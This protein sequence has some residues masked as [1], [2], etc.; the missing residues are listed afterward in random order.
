MKKI[1]LYLIFL[2]LS[3]PLFSQ[4]G[5]ERKKYIE[6]NERASFMEVNQKYELLGNIA[7][8]TNTGFLIYPDY[9]IIE[10]NNEEYVVF[11]YP[12]FKNGT[13][14]STAT[15][16]RVTLAVGQ[17][18]LHI[19]I[20]GK[21]SAGNT[22]YINGKKLAIQKAKF[23]QLSKTDHYNISWK[24]P[25]NYSLSF[26]VLTVPFKLR[27]KIDSTNFKM[28]TDVTLGPYVGLTKRISS[29]RRYYLTIP[30]TLGLS[31]INIDN[32]NT[33]NVSFDS[34]IGVVPGFTWSTGLIFQLEDFNI[35][36]VLGQDFASGVGDKWRYN[37]EIW[38]SFAIGYNFLNQK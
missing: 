1:Y 32:D 3:S 27:P 30:A 35:G 33:S 38:Y 12:D 24:Q 29:K 11:S 14:Y 19:D 22:I 36:F 20:V 21:D 13:Q 18:P 23:D 37:K 26:G 2:V 6:I 34:D 16:A 28:T 7:Y 17:S 25:R 4:Q 15:G 9:D 5:D 31:F 8:H 10:I